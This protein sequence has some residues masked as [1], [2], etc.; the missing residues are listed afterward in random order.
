MHELGHALGILG[1]S[2]NSEDVMYAS[3]LPSEN[4]LLSAKDASTIVALYSSA[5]DKFIQNIDVT[6][7][8]NVGPGAS[9]ALQAVI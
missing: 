7:M 9:P 8:T 3:T 5:G 6:K 1:H 2:P 4:A